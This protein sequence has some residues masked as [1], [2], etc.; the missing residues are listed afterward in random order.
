MTAAEQSRPA[1]NGAATSGGGETNRLH[2][3]IPYLGGAAVA[4]VVEA[5]ERD[6]YAIKWKTA[7]Q[8]SAQCP[9]HDDRTP[10]LS[11][12]SIEGQVLLNCHAGCTT[13]HVVG[14]LGLT[15]ADLFDTR[16]GVDYRY[17]NG[18]IVHRKVD[19]AS[20]FPQSNTD[21]PAELYRLSKVKEAVA[22]G[23]PV[24]VVEGEKDVHALETLGVTATTNPMGAS[25]WAKVDPSPLYGGKVLVLLDDDDAGRAHG[26]D[27]VASLAG[28]ADVA[29][30]LPKEGKDAADHIVAGYRVGDFVP[31]NLDAGSGSSPDSAGSPERGGEPTAPPLDDVRAWLER[32]I[33]TVTDED[34]D[35]LALWAAHTH[36][37]EET[38][39][40][41][42]LLIDSA[43]HGSGKTTV[44]EHLQRLCVHPVQMAALSSP[45]LL[46][47]MLDAGIRTILIDEA[48]RSLSKDKEGVGELLA[49]LNSGYK[50]GGARPV[51]VPV[52]GGGWEA[53]EMPTFAPVAMAGNNP[54]LPDDT[55]SRAI[56]VL[57]LPDIDGAI[58]D[59][60]WEILEEAA[61][62]LGGRLAAWASAVRDAVRATRPELPEKVRGRARERWA[63]LKRVAAAA[64]GRWGEVVD[65]MAVE[66]VERFEAEKDEGIVQQKP[67]VLL[68]AHLHEVFGDKEVFVPTSRLIDRLVD[69][70]PEIWGE[71]SAYGKRLT[72]QRLGR[73][74][75]QSYNVHSARVDDVRGYSRASL[76]TAFRRFGM[77]AN[78]PAGPIEPAEPAELRGVPDA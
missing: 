43:V 19:K 50:R 45:A 78:K 11:I 60:D 21:R 75:V 1:V 34:L 56:R 35:L 69:A 8:A 27:V 26:R 20:G 47:R 61:L 4:R 48:D 24:F 10:S 77:T 29:T 54:N 37:C 73:M 71:L 22:A 13:A 65:R 42:R 52:K 2:S 53:K 6:G 18:R 57:L 55:R 14:A 32:F 12:T 39:T 66:D 41:P 40:T 38:F 28:K 44:L 72:A 9:A 64:G 62:V 67:A 5:L 59:S 33:S 74:L 46:T 49:V 15:M 16:R 76:S 3:T 23:R 31:V 58:E 51:L 70:H 68:L 63:P 7:G 30:F 17:D 36:L 25:N